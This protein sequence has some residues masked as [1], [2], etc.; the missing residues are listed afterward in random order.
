[1]VK[2][3]SSSS[4][5]GKIRVNDLPSLLV[6]VALT[7]EPGNAGIVAAAAH[8]TIGPWPNLDACTDESRFDR[9]AT[10]CPAESSA[11]AARGVQMAA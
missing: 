5:I 1:M 3:L 7:L 2:I 8:H 4:A 9:N 6:T 11:P 10:A